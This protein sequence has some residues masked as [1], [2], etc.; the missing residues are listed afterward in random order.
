MVSK[1]SSLGSGE[2]GSPQVR[3]SSR[4][5]RASSQHS[6]LSGLVSMAWTKSREPS[7]LRRMLPEMPRWV[8][9]GGRGTTTLSSNMRV[10]LL[11]GPRART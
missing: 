5:L 11:Q 3:P 7:V 4:D 10:P 8:R 2:N 6:P 1:F 9:S